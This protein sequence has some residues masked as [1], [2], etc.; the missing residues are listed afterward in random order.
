MRI[1]IATVILIFLG[2]I[3]VIADICG[4]PTISAV[5]AVTQTAPAMKV[6]TAHNGYETFSSIYTLSLI[7]ADDKHHVFTLT[8]EI[9][10][11]LKGPYNRRNVYGAAIAY[12]PILSSSTHTSAMWQSVARSAFCEHASIIH[13]LGVNVTEVKTVVMQYQPMNDTSTHRHAPPYP[14]KLVVNCHDA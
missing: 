8:P 3:K 13:E 4:W 2:T 9:Y 10:D 5:A 7:D 1:L 6:F 12:G 11:G 14:N